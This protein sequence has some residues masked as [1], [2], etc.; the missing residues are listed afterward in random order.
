MSPHYVVGYVVNSMKYVVKYVV[1]IH[2]HICHGDVVRN[3]V[4]SAYHVVKYVVTICYKTT[5]WD[6]S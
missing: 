5:S 4:E 3:V 6:M 1:R 2:G